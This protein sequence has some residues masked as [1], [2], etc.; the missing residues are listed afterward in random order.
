M[1]KIFKK[2]NK[3]IYIIIL[4]LLATAS[5]SQAVEVPD[6]KE[7]KDENNQIVTKNPNNIMANYNLAIAMV[8][9][10]EIKSFYK[11]IDDF[12]DNFDI[13][14]FINILEPYLKA[15][16]KIPDEII[17]LNYAAFYGVITEDYHFAA[18]YFEKILNLTPENYNI[19]NFLAAV[20][21]EL[22]NYNYA[23]IEANR[24]IESK[25]N[26]FSHLILGIIHYEQGNMIKAFK[27]FSQTGTLG[28]VFINNN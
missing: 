7:M 9:L 23:L 18:K 24:A 28:T 8:N 25:N 1:I 12:G 5:L 17:F 4:I 6:W 3:I 26:K 21:L 13:D 27:E 19:R 10:G 20:H 2:S 15:Q 16:P 14:E 22:K 11:M